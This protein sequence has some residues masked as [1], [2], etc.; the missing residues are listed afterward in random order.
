[1]SFI[2]L[3]SIRRYKDTGVLI[4]ELVTVRQ[5]SISGGCYMVDHTVEKAGVLY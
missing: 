3:G 2:S 1:M 5:S 4:L